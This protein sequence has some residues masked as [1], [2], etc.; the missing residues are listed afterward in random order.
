[1]HRGFCCRLGH[2]Y[3]LQRGGGTTLRSEGTNPAVV[4]SHGA[5]STGKQ[6]EGKGGEEATFAEATA[7]RGHVKQVL[8]HGKGDSS[9]LIEYP[10]RGEGRQL[11]QLTT[12]AIPAGVVPHCQQGGIH[13]D[14][15]SPEVPSTLQQMGISQHHATPG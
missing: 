5:L 10:L 3:H 9:Y 1:M 11:C 12:G 2:K 4:G 13:R 8:C 15:P 7:G 6:A 14:P